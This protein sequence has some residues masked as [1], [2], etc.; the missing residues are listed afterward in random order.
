[1]PWPLRRFARP[2]QT[3]G[4]S[5]AAVHTK[6]HVP[7]TTATTSSSSSAAGAAPVEQAAA[8]EGPER[9]VPASGYVS[10]ELEMVGLRNSTTLRTGASASRSEAGSR[11][12]AA[13][14][15]ATSAPSATTAMSAAAAQAAAARRP[16]R[17]H[18]PLRT[19]TNRLQDPSLPL[20][21]DSDQEAV[22]AHPAV[23]QSTTGHS[24]P[25]RTEPRFSAAADGAVVVS[26]TPRGASSSG[27][28]IAP[29]NSSVPALH[30]PPSSRLAEDAS[31]ARAASAPRP[32]VPAAAAA[33]VAAA[34]AAAALA[35]HSS[36]HI[37]FEQASTAAALAAATSMRVARVARHLLPNAAELRPSESA[38]SAPASCHAAELRPLDTAHSA[39]ASSRAVAPLAAAA[40]KAAPDTTATVATPVDRAAAGRSQ[41]LQSAPAPAVG[42][43]NSATEA[44]PAFSSQ[45]TVGGVCYD[46]VQAAYV[47][48]LSWMARLLRQQA[49]GDGNAD[50]T[51]GLRPFNQAWR[52][53]LR[54]AQALSMAVQAAPATASV[55]AAGTFF[56]AMVQQ[57]AAGFRR[58]W[59]AAPKPL[60][61]A[62]GV[63]NRPAARPRGDGFDAVVVVCRA[64]PGLADWL[65]SRSLAAMVRSA[66]AAGVPLLPLLLVPGPAGASAILSTQDG[67]NS[68]QADARAQVAAAFG[69]PVASVETLAAASTDASRQQENTLGPRPSVQVPE[70]TGMVASGR[71]RLAR[72]WSQE[73]GVQPATGGAFHDRARFAKEAVALAKA[74]RRVQSRLHALITGA[75]NAK[76]SLGTA[77]VSKL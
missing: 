70:P 23:P 9:F 68:G 4:S 25:D 5:S 21:V 12:S 30:Q 24:V 40:S 65:K 74:S 32:A 59:A 34:A 28:F 45:S 58:L 77:A 20:V 2:Q 43:G 57:A 33:Q 73:E 50:D 36:A 55:A 76:P 16:N 37:D 61:N 8:V 18:K 38:H 75:D 11:E 6:P 44:A 52:R 39:P 62:A 41:Q 47:A 1:M 22:A 13:P 26:T 17:R 54:T 29:P 60:S 10:D 51:A 46:N 7:T 15:L 64:G 19:S 35:A 42:G 27:L 49:S 69:C 67:D 66:E 31:N 72:L 56:A 3:P 71:K 48:P 53:L 63:T 14:A